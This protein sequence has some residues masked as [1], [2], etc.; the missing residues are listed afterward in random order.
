MLLSCF[1]LFR[2]LKGNMW[3]LHTAIWS[4]LPVC[5]LSSSTLPRRQG[6]ITQLL[7]LTPPQRKNSASASC[8]YLFGKYS[9]A[10]QN[11]CSPKM[12]VKL[13]HHLQS[14]APVTEQ[15]WVYLFSRGITKAYLLNFQSRLLLPDFC[16]YLL[17]IACP[18][19]LSFL[20]WIQLIYQVNRIQDVNP[21]Q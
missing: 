16:R 9:R 19:R 21:P 8:V 2:F 18:H 4:G 12:F 3:S 5:H 14:Y 10:A 6:L 11:S 7:L 13:L 15:V 1:G 20:R 17:A